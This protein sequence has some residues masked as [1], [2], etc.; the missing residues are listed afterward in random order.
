MGVDGSVVMSESPNYNQIY[1]EQSSPLNWEEYAQGDH[2]F[3]VR[4]PDQVFNKFWEKP[5]PWTRPKPYLDVKKGAADT[6]E[7]KAAEN[8]ILP[9]VLSR[10]PHAPH[11]ENFFTAV[12]TKNPAM[13]NCHVDEAFRTCV[14]VLKCYESMKTGAKYIFKPE[15]FTA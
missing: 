12:R 10:P 15:D 6:R 1:K 8:W 9:V 5:K 13:L 4:A 7:S 11:L 2:P 3:V 14:T